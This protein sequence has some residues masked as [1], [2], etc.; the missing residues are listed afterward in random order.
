[1]TNNSP[2]TVINSPKAAGMTH[3]SHIVAQSSR[4][5]A[6]ALLLLALTVPLWAQVGAVMPVERRQWFDSSGNVLA[7][8]KIYT[9]SCGTVTPKNTYS[10]YLLSNAHTNPII[11]DTAGRPISGSTTTIYLTQGCY[12]FD[13]QNSLG[14]SQYIID[15]IYPS[16]PMPAS[17]TASAGT[18]LRGDYAWAAI[19]NVVTTTSTGSQ[20]DFAPGLVSGAINIIRCN[21]ATDLTLTGLSATS[22]ANGTIAIFESIHATG[23]VF[24]KHA[25]AGSVAANRFT[26]IATS[27]DT[28]IARGSAAF[29]YDSTSTAWRLVQHEQGAWITWTPVIGGATSESGQTYTTQNGRYRLSGRT[30]SFEAYV[31]LSAKGTITGSLQIKG[32]PITSSSATIFTGITIG[33]A[34]SLTS[35]VVSVNAYVGAS[36]TAVSLTMRTAAATSPT[37][38][39]TADIS[40]T[41]DFMVAGTYAVD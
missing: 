25:N 28:P 40:N 16:V 24:F 37:S 21:N 32:L 33:Q 41:T 11:L 15:N 22:I 31:V 7:G 29:V 27:G 18:F 2:Y 3:R 26:N 9:Y 1:M 20:N 6:I 17:G 14:V 12:K 10:D 23:N 30:V 35:S 36:A 4:I 8:G 19:E 13:V 39:A 5:G 34:N 38:M